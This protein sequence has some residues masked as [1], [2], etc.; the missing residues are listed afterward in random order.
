MG[1]IDDVAKTAKLAGKM[2]RG[3]VT[4]TDLLKEAIGE[5]DDDPELAAAAAPAPAPAL[6]V[7]GAAPA[8]PASC[9]KPKPS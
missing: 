7:V 6:R 8:A 4:A 5:T 2:H 9:D 1:F 3:E